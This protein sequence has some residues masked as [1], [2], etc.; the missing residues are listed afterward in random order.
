MRLIN[1]N[2]EHG[3]DEW[4]IIQIMKSLQE[5]LFAK[6]R[7]INIYNDVNKQK[8]KIEEDWNRNSLYLI[9]F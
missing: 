7:T 9:L 3:Y 4:T 1:Q 6:R 2:K 5:S 8:A